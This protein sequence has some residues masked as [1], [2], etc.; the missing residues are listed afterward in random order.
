MWKY[1]RVKLQAMG[2]D[3]ESLLKSSPRSVRLLLIATHS[4]LKEVLQRLVNLFLQKG[5]Q[6]EELC[7]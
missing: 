2:K 6:D 5:A 3:P 7:D 4:T 1:Y